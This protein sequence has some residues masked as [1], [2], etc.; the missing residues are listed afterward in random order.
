MKIVETFHSWE[1]Y[2]EVAKDAPQH[3][4]ARTG[5][6]GF[7]GGASFAQA[8]R[9]AKDGW[10]VHRPQVDRFVSHVEEQVDLELFQTTFE[11]TFDVAGSEVSI[12]RY[13]SG[14]PECMIEA[15]P[16]RIARKGRAVRLVIPFGYRAVVTVEQAVAR[17]AAIVAL[18]DLL[19]KA[20]HPVEIWATRTQSLGTRKPGGKYHANILIQEANDPLDI[21][22]LLFVFAH[23][24]AYRR[25]GFGS[26]HKRGKIPA[27]WD[28]QGGQ[29]AP[30]PDDLGEAVENT[31]IY[32]HLEASQDWS[33]AGAKA[34]IETQLAEILA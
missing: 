28:D 15:T 16:L 31:H 13:L 14:E 11:S 34:W 27:A 21:D 6:V 23:P 26:L 10:D 30:D 20:Q 19:A 12:D 9:L 25:I 32:P 24:A 17:G 8:L 7:N 29:V 2:V 4:T 1:D 22:R 33:E 5:A 3:H 18:A